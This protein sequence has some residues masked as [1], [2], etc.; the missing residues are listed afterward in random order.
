M[1]GLLLLLRELWFIKKTMKRHGH[2]LRR[3]RY[4]VYPSMRA[5]VLCDD[6]VKRTADSYFGKVK[7]GGKA[8]AVVNLLNKCGFFSNRATSTEEYEAIYIANNYDAVRETKLFAFESG[9]VLV[10]CVSEAERQNVLALHNQLSGTYPVPS[11]RAMPMPCAYE[12]SLIRLATRPNEREAVQSIATATAAHASDS[13]LKTERLSNLVSFDC[14]NEEEAAIMRELKSCI[15]AEML[16]MPIPLCAQ[17]GDLSTDNLIYGKAD[18]TEDFFWIDWEH[19]GD[20]VFFYDALFYILNTA[21]YSPESPV[22]R[23][24]LDGE[25]DDILTTFFANFGL[26]Y[27]AEHK[28]ELFLSFALIFLKERVIGLGRTAALRMYRDFLLNN[29]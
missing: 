12:T 7:R 2:R 20:R 29:I 3:G 6:T 13:N 22:L 25:Y 18:G 16:E 23:E 1:N 27:K 17:H 24:F 28:R 14:D 21:V 15:S 9:N 11:V 8:A 19:L 26:S 4:C 10:F 5:I